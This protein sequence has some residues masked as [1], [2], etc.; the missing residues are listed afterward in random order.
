MNELII[1]VSKVEGP[2]PGKQKGRVTDSTGKYWGVWPE[3]MSALIPGQTYK[4]DRYD[5][6]QY[7]GKT[8]YTL[9]AV[10]P[11]AGAAPVTQVPDNRI[12]N[13]GPLPNGRPPV[14]S[15][16]GLDDGQRRLDIFVCG[17][18]NNIMANPNIQPS[19]MSMMDML[20]LLHKLRSSWMGVFGPSP[21]PHRKMPDPI[22]SGPQDSGDMNG[23]YR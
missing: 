4:V 3:L 1:Q 12:N 7:M 17:A 20:D 21:L 15:P 10:T 16:V 14:N 13:G 5:Q 11:L 8:F 6:N 9:K 19:D 2:Q 18:F 23:G 22:T